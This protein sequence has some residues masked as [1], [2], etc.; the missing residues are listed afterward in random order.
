MV[1]K[2]NIL[3]R[4]LDALNYNEQKVQKGKATCIAAV[5]YLSK[6]EEMNFYQKFNR[7]KNLDELNTRAT[8]KTAHVSL[9]FDPSE[10]LS[11]EQLKNIAA[12]YMEKI[13]F[14]DQPYLV[15]NHSDAGHPHIHIVSTTIKADGSRINTHNIGKHQSEKARK[16]I[17][18]SFRLKKAQRNNTNNIDSLNPID[19]AKINYG[20]S[21]TKRSISNAVNAVVKS[22]R[23]TSLPELNAVLRQYNVIA[24]RCRE[25]SRTYKN[26]GLVYRILD[27]TGAKIGVPI[28][29]SLISGKPTLNNLENRFE[30]NRLLREP[31]K[32]QLTKNIDESLI[33]KPDNIHAL[34]K[35]LEKKGINTILRQSSDGRLYGITFVDNKSKCVFN[36]SDLGKAYSIAGIQNRINAKQAQP[37]KTFSINTATNNRPNQSNNTYAENK[38]NNLLNT[39][40][41]PQQQYDG[42]PTP[43]KKKK[44]KKR[45]GESN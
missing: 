41:D 30:E 7:L 29:A 11:D 19:P 43:F 17:E 32:E 2:I 9:N 20:K 14:G 12:T 35:S 13:G 27:D 6:P 37:T 8:T 42:I 18:E 39:I 24:D 38:D 22:Y 28:K 40:M 45:K 5:N 4:L 34:A 26:R 10:K 31:F 16:Q 1:A 36:G 21:E 3:K 33:N 15:Y 23:F 25:Q 44:R